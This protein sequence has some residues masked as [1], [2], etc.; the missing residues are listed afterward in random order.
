MKISGYVQNPTGET[1]NV[2][3]HREGS[4][5]II[6]HGTIS[7]HGKF[8]ADVAL[9]MRE[10]SRTPVSFSIEGMTTRKARNHELK[11]AIVKARYKQKEFAYIIGM[12]EA[13]LS[14]IVNGKRP[15]LFMHAELITD[16]LDMDPRVL[17][18]IPEKERDEVNQRIEEVRKRHGKED[19]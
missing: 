3:V 17:W 13:H 10:F 12:H 9:N 15:R 4:D 5:E 1:Q 6:G 19:K 2:G 16:L 7:P 8:E 18:P 14:G 11:A